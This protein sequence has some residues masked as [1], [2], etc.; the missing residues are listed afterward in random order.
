MKH[1]IITN[2]NEMYLAPKGARLPINNF[3]AGPKDNDGIRHV[4]GIY[5][6]DYHTENCMR[7]QLAETV[8]EFPRNWL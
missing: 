1:R 6:V 8:P 7:S 5:H 3:E 2:G 4:R